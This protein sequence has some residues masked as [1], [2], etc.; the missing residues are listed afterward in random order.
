MRRAGA[1][2]AIAALSGL[3]AAAA[4]HSADIAK[5][6]LGARPSPAAPLQLAAGETQLKSRGFIY[7][8][9]NLPPGPRPLLVL[10][11]GH[12]H[13]HHQ[14]IRMFEPWADHCGAIVF[15]PRAER[16]TWDIIHTARTLQTRRSAPATAPKKFGADAKR[17][18]A[19]LRDLFAAAP[20]DPAKVAVLGFSDGASYA[21]SLGLANPGL[22]KWVVAL[23]PGFALWPDQVAHAQRVFVAHGKSDRKLD[24]A[25]TRDGIVAPLRQAD[26]EVEFREFDG[27]H[28][29]VAPIIRDALR[30]ST[31]CAREPAP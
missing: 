1:R 12:S 16:I 26:V 24:F 18:D 13:D 22:F 29:L 17:L 14:F 9:A 6:E 19:E 4:A 25:N 23:S 7:R 8:P 5:G 20:I 21:L 2:L 30:L 10:L 15:A 28:I 27:D 11:H 3:L 31:G